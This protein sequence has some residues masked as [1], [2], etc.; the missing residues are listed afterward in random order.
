[1][2]NLLE[3]WLSV[4]TLSYSSGGK[5]SPTCLRALWEDIVLER[6]WLAI[7]ICRILP[8]KHVLN[9]TMVRWDLNA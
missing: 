6:L 9:L 4:L 1:M 8:A 3:E 7:T 5:C 2:I